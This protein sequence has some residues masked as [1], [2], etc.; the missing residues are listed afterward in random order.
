M[1][2]K[3]TKQPPRRRPPRALRWVDGGAFPWLLALFYLLVLLGVF[4]PFVAS[5]TMLYGSDTIQAQFYMKTFYNDALRHGNFPEWS[6][7]LY[8]GMPFVDAFHS[9]IFYPVSFPFKFL[10]PLYRA[11]GWVAIL[12]FLLGG[13]GMFWAAHRGWGIQ[14]LPA[15]ISG[16]A[17]LLAPYFISLILPGHDGKI[18]ATAW[19]PFG[20]LFL[21]LIWDHAR[22]RDMGLFALVVALIILTPHVQ[23]A[24]Y[25]L[26]AYAAYSIYRIVGKLRAEQHVPWRPA[27]GALGAVLVAAGISAV[28]FY[29]GYNYV[30]HYSPRAGEGR[31]LAFASSWSLHPEEIVDCVVPD[32]SGT[33]NLEGNTYWGRNRVSDRTETGGTVPLLLALS[34]LFVSRFRERWFFFGLGLFACI[35]GLGAHTPLFTLFYH[36]VPNVKVMRGPAMIMFLYLFSISLCAGAALDSLG[37][38]KPGN[39]S[40]RSKW[41]RN[42]LWIAAAVL[43]FSAVLLTLDTGGIMSLYTTL[44]YSGIT[45]RASAI[46]ARHDGAIVAGFWIAALM[47]LALAFLTARLNRSGAR[48]ALAGIA[49]LII[50][51]D[52]RIDRLYIA[53]VTYRN[54]FP[55][56]PA[57]DF[58]QEQPLPFR[59]FDVSSYLPGRALPDWA[60]HPGFVTNYFAMHG[61][62]ELTGYHG[63]QLRSYDA[64]LGGTALPRL[65]NQDFRRA[66]DL[67]DVRY[68]LYSRKILGRGDPADTTL[69][70]VQDYRGVA[71]YENTTVLPAARLVSCW[72][73]HHPDDSLYTRLYADDFDYRHCAIVDTPLPFASSPDTTSPGEAI[74]VSYALEE[75][76]VE[77]ES[78]REALLV[79]A[80][81]NYPAWHAELDGRPVPIITT[82]ATF[83]GVVVPAGKH[84]VRFDYRSSRLRIGLW[85]TVLSTLLALGAVFGKTLAERRRRPRTPSESPPASN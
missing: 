27:L 73:R 42:F 2:R 14:R 31:D 58:L 45:P 15:A 70:K 48:W 44:L 66:L 35:Y 17:Y 56:H 5:D 19:F 20:F 46:L 84:I 47:A 59:V 50:I 3:S 40:R 75:V 83:R 81:N 71:I 65:T 13:I 61:I 32:F 29:P 12:H 33:S 34:A 43:A 24:Y 28:Q 63:N 6:P 26:W 54:Y 69:R 22:L 62:A 41:K 21:K 79:V 11:L 76:A 55:N 74:V 78:S 52:A 77:V 36:V 7:Y 80:D 60:L 57:V 64:F 16:L 18:F 82:N 67:A 10:M 72:E 37:Q 23:M 39:G 85:I 49:A 8:G 4:W 25:A 53:P 9:D 68:L 38:A 1:A 51:D 30:K